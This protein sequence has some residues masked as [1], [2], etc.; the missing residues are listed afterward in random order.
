MKNLFRIFIVYIFISTC[1]YVSASGVSNDEEMGCLS[2]M[3]LANVFG[4]EVSKSK[5]ADPNRLVPMEDRIGP[6]KTG[7]YIPKLERIKAAAQEGNLLANSAIA[8]MY[9]SGLCGLPQSDDLAYEYMAKAGGY[10]QMAMRDMMLGDQM[11]EHEK[12]LIKG[13]VWLKVALLKYPFLS[14]SSVL[15]MLHDR[16]NNQP[17]LEEVRSIMN[18]LQPPKDQIENQLN[19]LIRM[20]FLQKTITEDDVNRADKTALEWVSAHP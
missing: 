20:A 10:L 12:G 7:D 1:G 16:G 15:K 8:E 14:E 19:M 9:S 11:G 4:D 3:M 5:N 18:S 2:F 17:K 6:F 13:I